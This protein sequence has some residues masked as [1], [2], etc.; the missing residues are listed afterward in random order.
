MM[1]EW[2]T[3]ITSSSHPP[4][5]NCGHSFCSS[6]SSQKLP[7]SHL[8]YTGGLH[9]VCDDCATRL[10]GRGSDV[11]APAPTRQVR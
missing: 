5:R 4:L 1:T 8:G 11:V 10:A 3:T 2:L 6:H 9:R 7:L